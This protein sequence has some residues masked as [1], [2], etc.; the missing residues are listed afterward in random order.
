MDGTEGGARSA[1]L[2]A[3]RQGT[4]EV[5]SFGGFDSG[6]SGN[7]P[8][9]SAMLPPSLK[10]FCGERTKVSHVLSAAGEVIRSLHTASTASPA[11]WG[12]TMALS[13]PRSGSPK[14]LVL[15]QGTHALIRSAVG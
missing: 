11:R 14:T 8:T 7:G 10:R 4:A 9:M 13:T 2:E 3:R 15:E 5:G 12:A 6:A 1:F